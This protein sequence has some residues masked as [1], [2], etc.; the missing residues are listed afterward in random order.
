MGSRQVS[1]PY[2]L[3]AMVGFVLVSVFVAS[4]LTTSRLSNGVSHSYQRALAATNLELAVT[5]VSVVENTAITSHTLGSISDFAAALEQAEGAKAAL[6]EFERTPGGVTG[7]LSLERRIAAFLDS[8]H[9]PQALHLDQATENN[10]VARIA[11]TLHRSSQTAM[12]QALREDGNYKRLSQWVHFLFLLVLA[13]LMGG[14][15]LVAYRRASDL[16][17]L[18]EDSERRTRALLEHAGDAILLVDGDGKITFANDACRRLLGTEV[19]DDSDTRFHALACSLTAPRLAD[20]LEVAR[21]RPS[22]LVT[23]TMPIG[24][25]GL[26]IVEVN[27]CDYTDRPVIGAVIVN[28]RDITQRLLT[29]VALER[30]E[31]F[32]TDLMERAPLLIYVKDLDLRFQR[33]NGGAAQLLDRSVDEIVGHTAAELFTSEVASA[34]E[35]GDRRAIADGEFTTEQTLVVH[36]VSTPVLATYFLL[37]DAS[38]EPYAVAAVAMD[39]TKVEELRATEREL[40]AGVAHSTD[41]M[42]T[43]YHGLINSWNPAAE[44][45]FGYGAAEIVGREVG[46]LLAPPHRDRLLTLVDAVYSGE[47][48]TVTRLTGQRKDGSTFEGSLA[49][50]PIVDSSGVVV[51]VSSAIHDCTAEI[52]LAARL[53][54]D[55]LTGLP[56]R[57]VLLEHMRTLETTDPTVLVG[58]PSPIYIAELHV[59]RLN[60]LNSVFGGS[61]ARALVRAVAER[62]AAFSLLGS[63]VACTGRGEF[64]IVYAAKSREDAERFIED[65]HRVVTVPIEVDAQV[66]AISISVGVSEL[67]GADLSAAISEVTFLSRQARPSG[68]N[69]ITFFDEF[70]RHQLAND[71]NTLQELR[72]ALLERR[73]VPYYQPI[74]ELAT[75]E[76]VGFEALVRWPHDTR[77]LVTPDQFIELAED[78]GLI[79]DLGRQI[80]L[81]A[82]LQ[83]AQWQ[84]ATNRPSLEI[85]VNVSV[86]ELSNSDFIAATKLMIEESKVDPSAVIFEITESS[87]ANAADTMATLWEVKAL[88][89][90]WSI[91]DFGTGYSSLS[92]LRDF[93]VDSM[94]IDRSF[95]MESGTPKGA[96]MVRSILDFARALD[97]A[98]I[99]EGIET[100]EQRDLLATLGGQRGQGY[101]WHQPVPAREAFELLKGWPPRP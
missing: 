5:K 85:H 29:Q 94:K 12:Q 57:D 19:R 44:Q 22:A 60:Q 67:T 99:A 8:G 6:G 101:F 40:R 95:V 24:E 97:L 87:L 14:V 63:F 11:L 10:V 45:L 100:F 36:D 74:V 3:G 41:A 18:S 39:M 76:I 31:L 49:A 64:A 91:D 73:L 9:Y 43:S 48:V 68:G 77:G 27:V 2:A 66:L 55:A 82:C 1:A 50:A 93:P 32:S 70:H 4:A 7:Y 34:L 65:V 25:D 17:R 26:T 86:H 33:V 84:R 79:V 46:V 96:V 98:T 38:G 54:T 89:I 53:R 37:R 92:Y 51:G 61:T 15:G 80:R 47:S 13:L 23:E 83:L 88:G 90:R 75:N 30:E 71:V 78:N 69:P 52:E 62:L 21:H 58:R 20:V 81:Q 16:R 56:N 72:I 28:I 42:V 35:T 59:D